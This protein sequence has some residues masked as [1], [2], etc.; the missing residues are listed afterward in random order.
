MRIVVG[1]EPHRMASVNSSCRGVTVDSDDLAEG[2]VEGYTS[3]SFSCPMVWTLWYRRIT[4]ERTE[5][6]TAVRGNH[7]SPDLVVEGP[8]EDSTLIGA[9]EG[10]RMSV[11]TGGNPLVGWFGSSRFVSFSR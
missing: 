2:M 4:S 9:E 11:E 8:N 5:E 1:W 6:A 10:A 7:P 3:V